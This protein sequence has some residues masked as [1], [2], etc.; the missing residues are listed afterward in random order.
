MGM[1]CKRIMRKVIWGL[2]R[3]LRRV[4]IARYYLRIS[5]EEHAIAMG[6]SGS[7]VCQLV[8]RAEK[9][10]K[11]ELRRQYGITGMEQIDGL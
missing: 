3:R 7:R 11:Y 10:I 9:R 8:K 5:N 6:V 2:P 1:H 4:I